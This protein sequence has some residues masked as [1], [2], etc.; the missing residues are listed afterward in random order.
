MDSLLNA[1][2]DVA[3]RLL[4]EARTAAEQLLYQV[5]RFLTKNR[6]HLEETE[7]TTTTA[8]TD[9]LRQALTGN[10]RDLILKRMDELDELTRP[11]AE[12]VMNISIKQAMSGK[13]IG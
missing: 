1:K 12:R 13:Q 6:E 5:E 3:A 4:I 8:Q 10:D 7:V 2:Q 9:L 11:F